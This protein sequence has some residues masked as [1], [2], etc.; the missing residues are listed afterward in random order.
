MENKVKISLIIIA[1]FLI[2]FFTG[3]GVVAT[4]LYINKQPLPFEKPLDKGPSFPG[5]P[6]RLMGRMTRSL[7][8][9]PDQ[10]EDVRKIMD[11][12]HDRMMDLREKNRPE[13]R[14]ILDQSQK[15][16][17]S[18]LTDEQK[19]KFIKL[20]KKM[21]GRF[22]RMEGREKGMR[23]GRGDFGPPPDRP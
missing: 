16:I 23:Q 2:G 14:G 15:E 9:T 1:V 10:Q 6:E 22:G 12:T 4:F 13:M 19:Q 17:A 11:K 5:N 21:R 7:D 20:R 18:I 8:L 3:T